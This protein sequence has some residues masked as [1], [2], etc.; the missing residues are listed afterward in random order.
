MELEKYSACMQKI[1]TDT[2]T[3]ASR[4]SLLIL[5]VDG[6]LT[7]GGI[8]ID[9]R[10]EESKKFFAQDGHGLMLV[11][12][13]GIEVAIISGRFSKAVEHRG[14]EL[15]IKNIIQGCK[16]KLKSFDDNFS[17][18]YSYSQTCFVGDD[19]V[20]SNLLSKVGL[21]VIVPNA[22]YI[23]Y[24]NEPHWT[25]PRKGGRGAV[26]DVCDLICI[27]KKSVK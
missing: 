19:I 10:G 17:Q 2:I 11:K 25:T 21:G 3:R 7:D 9:E 22:N 6:V 13:L 26:R 27:A 24:V 1:S 8:Y 18:K 16:D 15:G 4:I 12:N 14:K 23:N 20:D 5:D